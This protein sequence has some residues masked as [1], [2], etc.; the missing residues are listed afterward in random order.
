MANAL[1]VGG[2]LLAGALAVAAHLAQTAF[3]RAREAG[4]ANTALAEE[5]NQRKMAQAELAEERDNLEETV[6]ARTK[7]LAHAREAAEAANR[8][9]ST[10]LA[11]MSHELRT[12][13]NAII[14]YSEMLAEEAEDEGHDEMIPDLTKINAAGKHLLALINDILDLSKIEAGRMDL[15]LERFDVRQMLDEAVDTVSPLIAKNEQPPRHRVRRWPRHHPCR[16]HQA[17]T[18][19]LQPALQRSEVH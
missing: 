18:E 16:P 13:M 8:A 15:Y 5:I 6:D 17:A 7:E 3:R 2:F 11:N 14:G 19:P 4:A 10:F 1:L 12:P 9:K